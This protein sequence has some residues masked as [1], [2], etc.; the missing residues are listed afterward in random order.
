MARSSAM[1]AVW[2]SASGDLAQDAK[3]DFHDIGALPYETVRMHDLKHSKIKASGKLADGKD[4]D[5]GVLF[6]TYDLLI[7]GKTYLSVCPVGS[8]S[9]VST[10]VAS[11]S[12]C[13]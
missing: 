1:Q 8:L 9:A 3:R 13:S 10:Q 7:S 2:F 11:C 12:I 5:F 4:F 6:S